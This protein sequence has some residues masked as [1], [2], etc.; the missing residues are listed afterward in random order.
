[1]ASPRCRT[2]GRSEVRAQGQHSPFRQRAPTTVGLA[3]MLVA[4]SWPFLLATHTRYGSGEFFD[5]QEVGELGEVRPDSFHEGVWA[6]RWLTERGSLF[7][8]DAADIVW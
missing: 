2:H 7:A 5:G 1:M 4:G 3:S 8:K 6:H